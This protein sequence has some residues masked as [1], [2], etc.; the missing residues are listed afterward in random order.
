MTFE[1]ARKVKNICYIAATLLAVLSF[2]IKPASTVLLIL[3]AVTMAVC[4]VLSIRYY[5]CPFCD[6]PLPANGKLPKRCPNCGEL[7]R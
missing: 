2:V 1:T 3:A 6:R 7:L 4:I 5:R